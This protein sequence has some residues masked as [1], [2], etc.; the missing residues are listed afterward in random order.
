MST[1]NNNPQ[2]IGPVLTQQQ[3]NFFKTF[4]YLKLEGLLKDRIEDISSRFDTVMQQSKPEVI[5]WLHEA[6]YMQSRFILM[7]FIERQPELSSLLDDPR[8]DGAFSALLGKDYQYRASDA[9]IFTGDTYWHSDLYGAFF[10]YQH[11]KILF[12]LEPLDADS[13]AFQAIP[14]SHLFGDKFANQLEG[15]VWK[16][17]EHYGLKKEE[18]PSVTI[19]TQPGDAVIFDYRLKHATSHTSK[20]RRMFSICASEA[21]AEEDMPTLAKLTNDFLPMSGG[22][23]YQPEFIENSPPA[24]RQHLEQCLRAFEIIQAGNA[25][26]P[27]AS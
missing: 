7:Q 11:I 1:H 23:V 16:H 8:I 21:F 22:R 5:D 15:K 26:N 20:P 10:K 19:P 24:R 12:Y 2:K 18:V 14:G 9:N 3:K 13:G 25:G 4:G 27:Q 17:E 6:H